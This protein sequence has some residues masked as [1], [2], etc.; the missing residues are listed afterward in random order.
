MVSFPLKKPFI[1][2]RSRLCIFA[3][4]YF[5]IGGRSP[6]ILLQFMS[7]GILPVFS[8]GSFMVSGLKFKSLIHFEI[9]FF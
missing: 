2:I 5:A 7:K 6:K 9:F 3:F 4:L 8:S 1:L